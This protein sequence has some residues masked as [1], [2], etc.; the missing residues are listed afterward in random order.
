MITGVKKYMQLQSF[1]YP[2][3]KELEMAKDT[4]N[5]PFHNAQSFRYT[6]A[7]DFQG[8]LEISVANPNSL[9][10]GNFFID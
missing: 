4:C 8:I 9:L 3:S 10:D 7:E 5:K 6:V 1:S 2:N